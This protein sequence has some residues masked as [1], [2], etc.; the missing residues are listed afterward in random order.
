MK[1]IKRFV[2]LL[3][4]VLISISL[5][6]GLELSASTGGNDGSEPVP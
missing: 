4:I 2:Y 3:I 5:T 1:I 6:S